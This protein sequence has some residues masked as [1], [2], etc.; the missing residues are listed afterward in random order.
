MQS[1]LRSSV[2]ALLLSASLAGYAAEANADLQICVDA[3]RV[4][5]K[6]EYKIED[7][8]TLDTMFRDTFC[9]VVKDKRES[10]SKT[11]ASAAYKLLSLSISND[12]SQLADYQRDYCRDTNSTLKFTTNYRFSA[13]VV[14]GEPLVQFNACVANVMKGRS[15]SR[16]IE[17]EMKQR[18]ACYSDIKVAFRPKVQ[19]L[20]RTA[21]VNSVQPYNVDCSAVPKTLT[22]NYQTFSCR[23]TTWGLASLLGGTTQEPMEIEF[24]ATKPPPAPAAPVI[25]ATDSRTET[26]VWSRGGG[27]QP[28]VSCVHDGRMCTGT[29]SLPAGAKFQSAVYACTGGPNQNG[30]NRCGW[31][32]GNKGGDGW[33]EQYKANVSE[34]SG[35]LVWRRY[36]DGDKDAGISE[37]YTVT[38][39]VPHVDTP[40]VAGQRAAYIEAMAKYNDSLLNGPCPKPAKALKK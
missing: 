14:T 37:S 8:K 34:V 33:N 15:E 28:P 20:P 27:Y 18:D 31:S 5:A 24:P 6:S 11:D 32:Y 4:A 25:P 21:K 30:H 9:E 3:L 19:G 23:K 12:E 26:F 2:A 36:W 10:K 29:I 35:G 1:I 39:T 13:S 38:Y 16:G 40:E 17:Y 7:D 22:A